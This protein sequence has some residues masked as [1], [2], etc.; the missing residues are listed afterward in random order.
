VLPIVN[1]NDTVADHRDP[2]RRQRPARPRWSRTSCTPTSSLLLSDVDGLYDSH[3]GGT[4]STLLS[5][6]RRH[7]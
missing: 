4:G 6:V 2:V 7:Q 5:E 3:P 1:E